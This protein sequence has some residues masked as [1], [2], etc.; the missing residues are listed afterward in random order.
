MTELERI[1]KEKTKNQYTYKY[2]GTMA[3]TMIFVL[4]GVSFSDEIVRASCLGLSLVSYIGWFYYANKYSKRS[5]EINGV[6][7]VT[8]D[9]LREGGIDVDN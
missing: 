5:E 6:I 7:Q 9:T 2:L 4:L 8:K 3:L 1:F